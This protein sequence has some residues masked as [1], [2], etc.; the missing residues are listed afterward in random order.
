MNKIPRYNL[1]V[2]YIDMAM[3]E[4][5]FQEF[6]MN[7]KTEPAA[8][9]LYTLGKAIEFYLQSEVRIASESDMRKAEMYGSFRGVPFRVV[10]ELTL[11]G[12][13]FDTEVDPQNTEGIN[14]RYAIFAGQPEQKGPYGADRSVDRIA[15]VAAR[16]VR[17][18][19]REAG[20]P[21]GNLQ[22][23]SHIDDILG[24]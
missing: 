21:V 3:K 23:E 18:T 16:F 7:E 20:V 13:D 1:D 19:A 17:F 5:A 14:I 22:I 15:K 12:A 4:S 11:H 6:Q 10:A 9:L 8:Y 24:W 2:T